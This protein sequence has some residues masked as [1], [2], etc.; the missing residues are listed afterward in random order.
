[1][2]RVLYLFFFWG[3]GALLALSRVHAD[4]Y[5]PA[6]LQFS[7]QYQRQYVKSE[8]PASNK[9][10][11]HMKTVVPKIKHKSHHQIN[12]QAS[13]PEVGASSVNW[14]NDLV[15]IAFLEE[16][17]KK[18]PPQAKTPIS[19]KL[20]K[21]IIR[22]KATDTRLLGRGEAIF[23]EKKFIGKMVTKS[24]VSDKK[25]QLVKLSVWRGEV[26]STLKDTIFRW[27]ASQT[28]LDGGGWRVIW[29]TPVNYSIDA[30]L[31]FEGDFK[32]ALNDI[33]SLYQ[34]AKKPL[35]A[36]INNNQCLIKVSNK[37]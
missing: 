9:A 34:Y 20:L 1:M 3:G 16:Q 19:D 24:D 2:K 25:P 4:E 23:L 30:P 11:N 31:H 15:S 6:L 21:P 28:C 10:R 14:N 29:D 22:N 36:L 8:T 13:P 17:P 5:E 7:Q 35:Y 33:F 12:R 26:G 27:S 18:K 37:G 32:K